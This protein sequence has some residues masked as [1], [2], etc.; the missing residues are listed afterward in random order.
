MREQYRTLNNANLL[1]ALPPA[2]PT[3]ARAPLGSCWGTLQM[4]VRRHQFLTGQAAEPQDRLK[5]L[6]AEPNPTRDWL[7]TV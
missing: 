2:V 1:N 3:P 5:V 6:V 4:L 7:N